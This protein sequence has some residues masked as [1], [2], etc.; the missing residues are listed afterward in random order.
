MRW[1]LTQNDASN[2]VNV[3]DPAAVCRAVQEILTRR[4]PGHSFALLERVFDDVARLFRGEVPGYLP[5]D[6]LYHDLRHTLDMTLAMARLIDGHDRSRPEAERLGPRRALLGVIAALFHDSGYIRS[7]D[8]AGHR[9]AEFTRIHVTRSGHFVARYLARAGLGEMA[10]LA[11]EIVHFTGYEVDFDDIHVEDRLDRRLGYL[12]GSADLVGQMSDRLYLEKCRDFL[13]EEFVLAGIARE[14]LPDG[15]ERVVYASPEELLAKTPGFYEDIT[16]KRLDGMFEGV[17]H[18]AEAHFGDRNPYQEAI[19][20]N[21]SYLREVLEA[22]DLSRLR[23][24]PV[25]LSSAA[26]LDSRWQ[27]PG[28]TRSPSA[29]FS[30]RA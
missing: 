27:A 6:T 7:L 4:Y 26:S 13:Y 30:P 8:E 23:R 2:Q 17:H 5:C 18:Y 29:A 3:Q 12:L 25:S 24:I 9:G 16:R 14:E 15:D 1:R 20:L 22:G 10:P 11:R 19:D 28:K 21:I